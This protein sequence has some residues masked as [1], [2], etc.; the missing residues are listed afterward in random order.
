MEEEYR[1]PITEKYKTP[2]SVGSR[3]ARMRSICLFMKF[4]E[5]EEGREE[6]VVSQSAEHG[7]LAYLSEV[8]LTN[9]KG[10]ACW[11]YE[12]ISRKVMPRIEA[13]VESD[14]TEP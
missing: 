9:E 3:E 8:S 6:R 12:S 4:L 11:I 14:I 10:L 13:I 5:E 1:V 2:V 7:I